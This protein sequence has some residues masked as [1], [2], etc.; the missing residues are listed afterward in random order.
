MDP[1]IWLLIMLGLLDETSLCWRSSQVSLSIEEKIDQF[2]MLG[3]VRKVAGF[4]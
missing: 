3:T 4:S 2:I 1:K